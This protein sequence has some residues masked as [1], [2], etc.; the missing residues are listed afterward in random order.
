MVDSL[1]SL[2]SSGQVLNNKP[3]VIGYGGAYG[4]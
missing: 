3:D 2:N 4:G 1:S